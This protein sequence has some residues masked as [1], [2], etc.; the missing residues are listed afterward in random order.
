MA[1]SNDSEA[2]RSHVSPTSCTNGC[3][4]YGNSMFSGMC[5]KCFKDQGNATSTA[6]HSVAGESGKQGSAAR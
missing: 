4:F 6:S 2:A 5:S 1:S 3:G